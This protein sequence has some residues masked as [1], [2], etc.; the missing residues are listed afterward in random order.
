MILNELI[1]SGPL[2]KVWLSA[3]QERK[4]SKT[5]ALGVDVGESVEAILEQDAELPLRSSGPLMLG[6]VRIYSRKVGYL[7]DDCKEARERIS[8]AFRPG[9]VDLPEHQVLASHNAITMSGRGDFDFN[10]WSWDST[11]VILPPETSQAVPAISARNPEFG[12]FGYGAPRPS[13]VFGGSVTTQSRQGSYDESSSQMGS[14]DFS[15]VDLGL[16]DFDGN[17]TI[18]YG[19]D[20]MSS[21]G[22]EG[23][24][25][26]MGRGLSRGR[27]GSARSEIDYTGI[28]DDMPLAPM[29]DYDPMAVDGGYEPMDL[30]L[31]FDQEQ[32]P[33]RVARAS[34]EALTPPP[35]TPAAADNDLTPRTAAQIAARPAPI[36]KP[37][38]RPRLL[39]PDE[40]LEID[41][42]HQDRASILRPENYIPAN[43]EFAQMKDIFADP[44]AH[45]LPVFK[46]GGENW[47]AVAP[48][49]AVDDIIELFSF[50]N[51]VLRRGRA[52]DEPD[53][54]QLAKKAR[55]EAQDEAAQRGDE[56][57]DID[58]DDV[59]VVRRRDFRVGVDPGDDHAAPFV[60]D[61]YD[62]SFDVDPMDGDMPAMSPLG[63]RASRAPSLAL[64][65]AE[66][67]AHEIQ[68]GV[69]SG[70][71]TLAMFDSRHAAGSQLSQTTSP[72]GVGD[73]SLGAPQ[74]R[75]SSMA[76]GLLR[77]EISA[78]DEGEKEVS[79]E[80][81]ANNATKRAASA[82]FFEMLSLGTRDCVKLEQP[83]PFGDIKI[84]GKDKL[85]PAS[86]QIPSEA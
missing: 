85:W 53:D 47:T 27:S 24:A 62:M 1:K 8:L 3:H 60:A 70:D 2:A 63:Y 33:E 66:S 68:Y 75:N 15:G 38:K 16:G 18:E 69:D 65:R 29:D 55:I 4:L 7:F 41:Q 48:L 23:S 34:T 74:G 64:S 80:K 28:G 43:P 19:R 83:E 32:E 82:F 36:A 76:M 45:F 13:S 72:G 35:A 71:F 31:N 81:L 77:K 78:I 25:F 46:V 42:T 30:E 37:V 57:A 49:G 58:T 10:D 56:P 20:R 67:I 50:P 51:N 40:A 6:V 14:N 39:M 11:G 26:G 59:E 5:Q 21:L 44:S 86:S 84:S 61:D 12:G 79:F 54:E 17:D 9:V 22:R 52:L 73:G